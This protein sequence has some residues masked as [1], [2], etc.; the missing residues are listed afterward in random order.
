MVKLKDLAEKSGFSITTVSRALAGYKDVN[1]HTRQHIIEIALEMGYQPNMVARQLRARKTHT[2]GIITPSA[3]G[4]FADD[5]FSELLMSVGHAAAQHGYDLLVTAKTTADEMD[6]YRRIVGGNRVDGMVIARTRRRDARIAYLRAAQHPFVVSGRAAPDEDSDFPYIDVDSQLGIRMIVNHLTNLGHQHIALL[7]PPEKV[8]FTPY[9]LAGYREGLED[10]GLPFRE[11]YVL[12][13]DL[14]R[15]GGQQSAHHLLENYPQISAIVACNDPMAIGAM[16][17]VQ[18][19]QM[20]VG[21]DVA[22]TGFDD[23]AAADYTHPRLT[24]VR[25]PI[26]EIGQRLL[27]MLIQIIHQVPVEEP[28]VLLSP[29]LVVRESCGAGQ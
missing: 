24:T 28:Q 6:A 11:E 16:N 13:S 14:S 27:E 20:R 23:I 4:R 21:H 5:F 25:Q 29:E 7:L 2:V 1:E 8:A 19:R 26:S 17:A 9:R 3:S 10:A 18:T 12:H 15:N 22:V